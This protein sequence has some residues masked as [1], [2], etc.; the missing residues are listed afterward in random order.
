MA[1]NANN[2]NT[3][4]GT[5][6]AKKV[7]WTWVAAASAT[8]VAMLVLF[9]S[10]LTQCNGKNEARDDADRVKR[11]LHDANAR[12][13]SLRQVAKGY[14]DAYTNAL[15]E[16]AELQDSVDILND[17]IDFLNDSLA[18]VNKDLEE[19]RNR[20]CVR[21][22]PAKPA[23][24]KPAPAKPAPAKPAP[25]KPAPAKPTPVKPAPVKPA[26]VNVD[27]LVIISPVVP[28]DQPAPQ[29]L[30]KPKTTVELDDSANSGAIVVGGGNAC[31]QGGT[32]IKLENGSVNSGAIVVGN[33]NNVVV[34]QQQAVAKFERQR[35]IQVECTVVR[36]RRVYNR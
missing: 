31:Q 36:S 16:N 5:S 17:T 13:D 30:C 29:Q 12:I 28:V 26:P 20:R 33:G 7:D 2:N 15:G 32:Q 23:P 9:V 19:C 4:A 34:E 3:N 6:A 14:G 10:L 22:T 35:T 8:G 18:V 27:T 1:Q 25:V 24:A 21:P 11:E